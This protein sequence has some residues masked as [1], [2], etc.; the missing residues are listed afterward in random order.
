MTCETE[1]PLLLLSI[2]LFYRSKHLEPFHI[3][4]S[5]IW[6]QEASSSC[7]GKKRQTNFSTHDLSWF[8]L[9]FLVQFHAGVACAAVVC[10][11]P[12][13]TSLSSS[14]GIHSVCLSIY[15]FMLHTFD[16]LL[17]SLYFGGLDIQSW[18]VPAASMKC[19]HI[20]YAEG[21]IP[22]ASCVESFS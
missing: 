13:F 3:N 19:N 7:W 4:L 21:I 14:F 16:L 18:L 10:L 9:S 2:A 17:R 15:L 5:S 1:I 22:T 12:F 8:S 20:M 11:L 6:S